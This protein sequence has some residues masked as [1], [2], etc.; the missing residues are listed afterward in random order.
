MAE[1]V[2][3]TTN[4]R[5]KRS[6]PQQVSNPTIQAIEQLQTYILDRTANGIGMWCYTT[7]K[8]KIIVDLE[9]TCFANK[10]NNRA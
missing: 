8:Y 4:T 6:C 3:C 10:Y 1:A 9:T 2:T 5:D 7:D